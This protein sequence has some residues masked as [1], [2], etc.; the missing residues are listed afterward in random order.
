MRQYASGSKPNNLVAESICTL[1]SLRAEMPTIS[2]RKLRRC[3]TFISV[4]WLSLICSSCTAGTG[5]NKDGSW[6]LLRLRKIADKGSLFSADET[7]AEL[8]LKWKATERETLK[9]PPDCRNPYFDRSRIV[10]TYEATQSWYKPTAEGIAHMKIPGAFINPPGESGDAKMTYTVSRSTNCTG[11]FKI[12]NRTV[13][14]L[15]FGGLPAFA[16]ITGDQLRHLMNAEYLPATDGVGSFH[17]KGNV[18]DDYGTSVEF[19]FRM[20]APCALAATVTQDQN[21]G[22][23]RQRAFIKFRACGDAADH[24]FC[25]NHAPFTWADGDVQDEM[26]N[27]EVAACGGLSSFY[28]NEPASGQSPPP[29]PAR[30][31]IPRATPCSGK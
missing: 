10:T 2:R 20:G 26:A 18:D 28:E 9:Q 29:S 16:C 23:R 24:K 5:S 8:D 4:G 6:L 17:Y 7:G 1:S 30:P 27:S 14:T 21:A 3:L 15:E 31:M 22:Y 12:M 13:A 19:A 11:N 25:S